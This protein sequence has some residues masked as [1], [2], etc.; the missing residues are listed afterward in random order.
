M[1]RKLTRTKSGERM[2]S[3][4]QYD[5]K[6]PVSRG[7]HEYHCSICALSRREELELA[8]VNWSSPAR[9]AKEFRVSR[10]SVYRHA[11][12]LALFEKRRRNVRVALERIIENAGE[13]EVSAAAVVG[14]VTAYAKINTSGQWIER[15]EQVSMNQLFDRMTRDEMEAYAKDGQLPTWFERAVGA[16]AEDSPDEL[17]LSQTIEK[18]Q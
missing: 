2:P 5:D 18:Q 17:D 9:I 4:A 7:R 11:H 10:D 16:T 14:A 12:A 13:V 1:G 8:F 15:T 6:K 3:K